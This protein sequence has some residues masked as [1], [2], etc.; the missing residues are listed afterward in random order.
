MTRIDV[1]CRWCGRTGVPCDRYG[2]QWVCIECKDK[3]IPGEEGAERMSERR[4]QIEELA[5]LE[6]EFIID[7]EPLTEKQKDII[8]NIAT[9]ELE[10]ERTRSRIKR[11]E[12]VIDAL[13]LKLVNESRG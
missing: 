3:P 10:L 11:Y 7:I 2:F 8:E 12:R 1:T 4:R 13:R 6:R 5:Y 9:M